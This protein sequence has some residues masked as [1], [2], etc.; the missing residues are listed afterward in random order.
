MSYWDIYGFDWNQLY[1]FF[2]INA[3]DS[4]GG[5]K[6]QVLISLV[7]SNEVLGGQVCVLLSLDKE[8]AEQRM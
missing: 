4:E 8:A 1:N 6:H 3:A 2:G 5:W 7:H